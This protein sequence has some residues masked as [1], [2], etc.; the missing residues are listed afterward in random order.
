MT[1]PRPEVP[2]ASP[3]PRP[4]PPTR[5][6]YSIEE[7]AQILNVPRSWL[8]DKVTARAVPHTRLGRHVRL[9]DAHLAAIIAI[10]ERAAAPRYLP[11]ASATGRLRRRPAS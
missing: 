7:A 5:R 10:G 2:A 1:D 6:L 9:T 4:E 8:R 3:R 11:E